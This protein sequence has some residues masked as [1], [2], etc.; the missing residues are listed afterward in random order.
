MQNWSPR[1][2]A[3]QW[4]KSNLEQ[5]SSSSGRYGWI[6]E[7]GTDSEGKSWRS[8]KLVW[9][10]VTNAK[11][12]PFP[13]LPFWIQV[14]NRLMKLQRTNHIV[15]KSLHYYNP[16]SLTIFFI[17]MHFETC[18]TFYTW[19]TDLSVKN[20]HDEWHLKKSRLRISVITAQCE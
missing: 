18:I 12:E 10:R 8:V 15:S 17:G 16:C 1:L 11:Y 3:A 5:I 9:V 13:V 14:F 7:C 20:L 6:W 19:M 4:W 2:L